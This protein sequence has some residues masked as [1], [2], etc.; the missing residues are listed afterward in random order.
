MKAMIERFTS[1]RTRI[2]AGAMQFPLALILASCAPSATTIVSPPSPARTD[3]VVAR[4]S[5]LAEARQRI[6]SHDSSLAAAYETLIRSADRALT[7]EPPSVVQKRRIPPSG[8][9]HDYM[10]MGTY[11]WPDSTKPGGVPYVRHDGLVNPETL[12]DFDDARFARML[13]AV[14]ALTL[15]H[16]F[17][18]DPKYSRRAVTFLRVWF[19]DSATRMNPNLQYAQAIP[20]VTEGRGIG[21]IDT[22]GIAQVIDAVQLLA[23]DSALSAADYS[24]IVAWCRAYMRWLLDS[25]NGRDEQ[26]ARNNH[27]TWYDVQVVSLALFT[28]DTTFAQRL[29]YNETVPRIEVQIRA[30]GSQPLEL[31]RTRPIHYSAFNL[32]AYTELAEMARH[33][34]VDLWGFEG[35]S[36]GSIRKALIFLAPYAD[37]SRKWSKPD[38]TPVPLEDI[39][40]PFRR[41]ALAIPDPRFTAA[42]ATL[43]RNRPDTSRDRLFY[44]PA[45]AAVGEISSIIERALTG[46]AEKLRRSAT[47]LDPANGYPRFVSASGGSWQQQSA[48]QWTSG[49]FAGT[50][51]Y[52]Y[53]L[54]RQPEW[55]DLAERWTEGLESNKSITT[56]H[57]LGFMIF[58]SFGRGYL[59]TGN[60]HYK[61]VVL[62]AARS[63]ATR[64]NPR[65][66]AI[67]SWNTERAKDQ[68]ATWKYPVIIDNLMNLELLFWAAENGGDPAWKQIA[69]QHALTSA[70]AHVRPDG[71]T[72]HVALF[73]PATGALEKTVTWQGYSDSSAWARGQAWAIYGFANAYAHTRRPELLAAAQK[74][75]D[76]FIAH[77][78]ADGVP[79]WDF[80]DPAI[81]NAPRDASAAAIAASGLLDLARFTDAGASARYRST[82]QK[83]L[84]TLARDYTAGPESAAILEHSVGG[85]PQNSEV[86]VGIIYADYYYVE[87]LLKLSGTIR[88]SASNALKSVLPGLSR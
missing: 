32:D 57:D 69:E 28:G 46:A 13:D 5:F 81:P 25:K 36:G 38:V 27:G 72:A 77:L 86:D 64:Y 70:R 56:T 87:A 45:P 41:A 50:L 51:W 26:A 15:A 17:T 21:I 78:P 42:L 39:A 83:I 80:R 3:L 76:Y 9:P 30:D 18:G 19:I 48:T 4:E 6:Q 52:M 61:E 63:L 20:G 34:G 55:K 74:T 67:K 47:T 59:L 7:G 49:F 29:L 65:V 23:R 58:D 85:R 88:M 73:D 40:A 16:Y 35:P 82:A 12:T 24:S 33:V 62:D 44:P 31:E 54:A 53:Q 37:T 71:S 68:R 75:A 66:G 84:V 79:Y 8:N 11:W 22:R 1:P 10:S 14:Q 2:M 60:P 43:T